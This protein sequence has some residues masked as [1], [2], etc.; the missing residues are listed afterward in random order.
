MFR[1]ASPN[2]LGLWDFV[3]VFWLELYLG[4]RTRMILMID[5]YEIIATCLHSLLIYDFFDF[6]DTGSHWSLS[7]RCE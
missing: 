2:G 6:H 1:L 7:L 5:F 4:F 3:S